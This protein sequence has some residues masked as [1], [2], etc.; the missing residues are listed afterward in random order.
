MSSPSPTPVRAVYGFVL[1][2]ATYV[3]FG[4]SK[5]FF[6]FCKPEKVFYYCIPERRVSSALSEWIQD[7][8]P[9]REDFPQF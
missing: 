2:L 9:T 6:F 7:F 1:Y 4:K 3:G 5:D 8:L